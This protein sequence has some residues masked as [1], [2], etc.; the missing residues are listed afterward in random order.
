MWSSLVIFFVIVKE[1]LEVAS[2]V[3]AIET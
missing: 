3:T 2:C 1:I